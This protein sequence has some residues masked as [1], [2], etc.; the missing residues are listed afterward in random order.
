MLF[1]ED[2][3]NLFMGKGLNQ[4]YSKFD[5]RDQV[6]G[7]RWESTLGFKE[8]WT[9]GDSNSVVMGDVY[10]KIGNVSQPAVDAVQRIQQII[11]EIQKPLS[12]SSGS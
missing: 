4:F 2:G 10:V 1:G 8:Q 5:R 12:E 3:S 6:E 9:Q 7:D 11:T